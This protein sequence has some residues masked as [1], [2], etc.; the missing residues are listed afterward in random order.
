MPFISHNYEINQTRCRNAGIE[1]IDQITYPI[2]KSS[3]AQKSAIRIR[4]QAT[5]QTAGGCSRP[6]YSLFD[7]H[8]LSVG[9]QT[10]VFEFSPVRQRVRLQRASIERPWMTFGEW[11]FGGVHR[12]R[13]SS[14]MALLISAR[15][16]STDSGSQGSRNTT[17]SPAEFRDSDSELGIVGRGRPWRRWA[18]ER[19]VANRSWVVERRMR[20]SAIYLYPGIS[21]RPHSSLAQFLKW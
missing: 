19:L 17:T 16:F 12:S 5:I 10:E 9:F 15:D 21:T 3:N 18:C 2:E 14:L 1:V 20:L 13:R 7:I 8:N 4:K 11:L 6:M